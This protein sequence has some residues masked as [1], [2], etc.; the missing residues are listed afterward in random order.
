[1]VAGE[2]LGRGERLD[3]GV[4]LDVVKVPRVVVAREVV[5]D[6]RD[7]VADGVEVPLVVL[8]ERVRLDLVGALEAQ[9]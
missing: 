6:G 2:R 1:M 3:G 5:D 7:A 8:E 4:V 9:T